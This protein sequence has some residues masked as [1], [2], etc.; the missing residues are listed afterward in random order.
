LAALYPNFIKIEVAL[1]EPPPFKASPDVVVFTGSAHP[2]EGETG[3][4]K[5]CT[6]IREAYFKPPQ[7]P[8]Y[9]YNL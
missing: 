5:R 7:T 6:C 9:Y 3:Q 8:L 2:D 1:F 4:L